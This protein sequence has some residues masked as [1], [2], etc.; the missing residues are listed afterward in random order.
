MA[1]HP[2]PAPLSQVLM[3][4]AGRP[5]RQ[6]MSAPHGQTLNVWILGMSR[7]VAVM[8]EL[9]HVQVHTLLVAAPGRHHRCGAC[10]RL[11]LAP[12]LPS[13]SHSGSPLGSRVLIFNGKV[14]ARTSQGCYKDSK[15]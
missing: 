5:G 13:R 12:P 3:P 10:S 14:I 1:P 4:Q 2:P 11:Y 7:H 9:G 8:S 6:V 15:S